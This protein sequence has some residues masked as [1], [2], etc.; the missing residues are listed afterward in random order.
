MTPPRDPLI[1][2]SKKLCDDARSL[3][4]TARITVVEA[5]K[6]VARSHR[7]ARITAARKTKAA[8]QRV[9]ARR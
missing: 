4:E 7:L 2:Y 1:S 9:I 3:R 5:K 8:A 6:A